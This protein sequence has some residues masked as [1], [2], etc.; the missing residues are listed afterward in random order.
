MFTRRFKAIFPYLVAIDVLFS[1][2]LGSMHARLAIVFEH[3]AMAQEDD[4]N[5]PLAAGFWDI[6]AALGPDTVGRREWDLVSNQELVSVS[7]CPAFVAAAQGLLLAGADNH[8]LYARLGQ[9]AAIS[10]QSDKA[11]RFFEADSASIILAHGGSHAVGRAVFDRTQVGIDFGTKEQMLAAAEASQGIRFLTESSNAIDPEVRR[12]IGT[13]LVASGARSSATI[14]AA[15]I[16]AALERGFLSVEDRR[17][18]EVLADR[19]PL[20]RSRTRGNSV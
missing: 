5:L 11:A 3:A 8:L 20:Y 14:I 9:C 19:Y 6:A 17:I 15:Y 18:L 12:E 13:L 7:S 16:A 4:G 2:V 1:I 10:R